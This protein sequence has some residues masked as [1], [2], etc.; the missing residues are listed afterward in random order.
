M[1]HTQD[2]S[3][4]AGIKDAHGLF[5]VSMNPPRRRFG[6]AETQN[7][8]CDT[9]RSSART[10]TSS[11]D[12]DPKP[13]VSQSHLPTKKRSVVGASEWGFERHILIPKNFEAWYYYAITP[14]GGFEQSRVVLS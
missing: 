7:V 10:D 1:A 9:G 8:L 4:H 5:V 6:G 3:T 13:P 12:G 14:R 2:P 11:F